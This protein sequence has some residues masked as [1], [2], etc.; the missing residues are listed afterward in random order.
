[1][2]NIN[3]S[4]IGGGIIIT[5]ELSSQEKEKVEK[6]LCKMKNLL[7]SGEYTITVNEKNKRFD[8]EYNVNDE[9]RKEILNSLTVDDCIQVDKNTNPNFPDSEIYVFLKKATLIVYGENEDVELYIKMYLQ[10]CGYYDMTIVISFH[11]SKQYE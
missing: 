3:E 2:Y 1:M 6:F 7:I 11:K 10:N 8:R 4:N 9:K 5:K